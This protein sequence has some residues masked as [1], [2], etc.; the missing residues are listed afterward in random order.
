MDHNFARAAPISPC[1]GKLPGAIIRLTLV[2]SRHTHTM[3][4]RSPKEA[5][6]HPHGRTS[7]VVRLVMPQRRGAHIVQRSHPVHKIG[8]VTHGS[9]CGLLFSEPAAVWSHRSAPSIPR[10]QATAVI[11]EA[12]S[13]RCSRWDNGPRPL[14][15]PSN[16]PGQC[17]CRILISLLTA[18]KHRQNFCSSRARRAQI[19]QRRWRYSFAHGSCCT[20]VQVR[21]SC[22]VRHSHQEHSMVYET[23][24]IKCSSGNICSLTCIC[25]GRRSTAEDGLRIETLRWRLECHHIDCVLLR[26]LCAS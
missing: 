20:T 13:T 2:H 12:C 6:A 17:L 22:V 14:I 8:T 15:V 25:S 7:D 1:F 4:H 10:I 24:S 3:P 16:V 18:D 19:N 5:I 11:H 21:N 26:C 9:S 23:Q